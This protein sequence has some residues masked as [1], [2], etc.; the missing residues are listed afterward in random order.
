MVNAAERRKHRRFDLPCRVQMEIPDNP[1][2]NARTVNVSDGGTCLVS[3]QPVE[4]GREVFIRL[5]IP[6]DTANT[7]FLEHFAAR[8]QVVRCEPSPDVPA[9]AMHVALSFEKAL[10]LDLP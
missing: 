3:D 5:I 8:A 4:V 7:F 6:R 1:G 9:G 2:L 10:T